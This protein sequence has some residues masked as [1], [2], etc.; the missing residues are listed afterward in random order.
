MPK[1]FHLQVKSK[2]DHRNTMRV[3]LNLSGITQFLKICYSVGES[4]K[5]S[6]KR[7]I[8]LITF[9]FAFN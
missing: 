6:K 3:F 8:Q 7:S 2:L 9:S 4:I 1:N 5:L